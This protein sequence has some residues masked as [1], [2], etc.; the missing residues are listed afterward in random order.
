MIPIQLSKMSPKTWEAGAIILTATVKGK[1]KP[2]H[3]RKLK[4]AAVKLTFAAS[5]IESLSIS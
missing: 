3:P 4:I 1:K 5:H 2:S